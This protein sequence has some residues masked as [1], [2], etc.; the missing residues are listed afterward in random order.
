MAIV[1]TVLFM[2]KVNLLVR[3]GAAARPAQAAAP[4]IAPSD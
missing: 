2:S 3:G 1:I 4:V